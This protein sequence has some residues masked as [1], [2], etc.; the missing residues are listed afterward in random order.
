MPSVSSPSIPNPLGHPRLFTGWKLLSLRSCCCQAPF[1]PVCESSLLSFPSKFVPTN[2]VCLT[3]YAGKLPRTSNHTGRGLLR[4]ASS[5]T[6]TFQW[7][8]SSKE[9]PLLSP[10]QKMFRDNVKF[11]LVCGQP[12]PVQSAG[13]RADTDSLCETHISV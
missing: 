2:H 5:L 11:P 6:P 7:N 12:T 3:K 9:M 4:H 1:L 10:G 8:F 13:H